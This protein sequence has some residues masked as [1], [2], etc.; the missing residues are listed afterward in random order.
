MWAKQLK[1]IDDWTLHVYCAYGLHLSKLAQLT[2][3]GFI[4]FHLR[5]AV[6]LV[7][8]WMI[9]FL[10]GT[11]GNGLRNS[12]ALSLHKS[13]ERTGLGGG[14]GWRRE[15]KLFQNAGNYPKACSNQGEFTQEKYPHLGKNRELCVILNLPYSQVPVPSSLENDSPDSFT[16]IG[17][18]R[19][20][21]SCKEFYVFIV[22]YFIPMYSLCV[23]CWWLDL[24]VW[25][26]RFLC[27]HFT[28]LRTYQGLKLL[29]VSI[30]PKHIQE[31]VL[32]TAAWSNGSDLEESKDETRSLWRKVGEWELRRTGL[33]KAPYVS[34]LKKV[35]HVYTCSR[36]TWEDLER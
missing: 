25:L 8:K 5:C 17:R 29:P 26:E 4:C 28:Y 6:M 13:N 11:K 3:V 7:W 2:L 18:S 30:C 20:D 35:T 21:L 16:G 23:A 14:V 24:D 36:R 15:N 32:A 19:T 10:W 27:L 33:W 1:E 9:K 34:W 31:T 12:K 22:I